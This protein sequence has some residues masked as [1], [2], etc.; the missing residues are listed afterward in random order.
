MRKLKPGDRVLVAWVQNEAVVVD[1]IL[2][3]ASI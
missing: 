1:I 2:P 3:A